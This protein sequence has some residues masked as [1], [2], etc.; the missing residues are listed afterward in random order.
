M[1]Y[2]ED[3]EFF[4]LGFYDFELEKWIVLGK[5]QMKLVCWNYVSIPNK[6]EIK[7]YKQ[8]LTD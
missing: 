3:L 6:N 4:D 2:D 7:K 5:Y 1:V 8:V